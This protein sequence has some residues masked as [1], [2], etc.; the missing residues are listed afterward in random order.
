MQKKKLMVNGK[1][2]VQMKI[3]THHKKLKRKIKLMKMKK[4]KAKKDITFIGTMLNV[5]MS[6]LFL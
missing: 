3:I 6:W 4:V 1:N 2:Q 5:Y